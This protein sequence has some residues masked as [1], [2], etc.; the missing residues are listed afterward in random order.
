[1]VALDVLEDNVESVLRCLVA[2]VMKDEI[3][4]AVGEG[5]LESGL[6]VKA[7]PPACVLLRCS[8]VGGIEGSG[9]AHGHGL[10]EPIGR[11]EASA[12]VELLQ[13]AARIDAE[14]IGNVSAVEAKG[15]RVVIVCGS[16]SHARDRGSQQYK[17]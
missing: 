3:A 15:F 6:D 11:S 9:F 2:L 14:D 10:R 16:L 12:P 17:S 4:I 1:M 7:V 13:F 8:G 5:D